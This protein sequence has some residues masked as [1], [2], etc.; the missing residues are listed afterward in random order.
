MNAGYCQETQVGNHKHNQE[1]AAEASE[2]TNDHSLSVVRIDP[3]NARSRPPAHALRTGYENLTTYA[4]RSAFEK[5][6][7]CRR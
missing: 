7:Y 4:I 2:V 5:I 3:L 6:R 1:P